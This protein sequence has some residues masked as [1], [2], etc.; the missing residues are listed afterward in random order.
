MEEL[1]RGH[2]PLEPCRRNTAAPRTTLLLLG[3]IHSSTQPPTGFL[4]PPHARHSVGDP[5]SVRGADRR[6]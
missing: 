4:S 2:R 5:A 6:S 1:V 3:H